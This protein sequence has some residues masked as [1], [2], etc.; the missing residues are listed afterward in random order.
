MSATKSE[1]E[2]EL[3]AV[4]TAISAVLT[5]SQ[6]Y[7]INGRSMTRANLKELTALKKELEWK[8]ADF[9]DGGRLSSPSPWGMV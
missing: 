6:S 9:D 3:A 5:G 4:K 2:T 1:L 7:T 8:I